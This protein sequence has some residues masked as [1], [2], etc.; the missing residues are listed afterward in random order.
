MIIAAIATPVLRVAYTKDKWA[1]YLIIPLNR[2]L[3]AT[4]CSHLAEPVIQQSSSRSP[5]F[6]RPTKLCAG[7]EKVGSA[8][9]NRMG[10]RTIICM[11]LIAALAL[12]WNVLG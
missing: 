11:L 6:L 4:N 12:I 3:S 1:F 5:R 8:A 9:L 10:R 2:C 7:T